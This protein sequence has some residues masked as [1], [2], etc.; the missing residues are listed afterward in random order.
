MSKQWLLSLVLFLVP[1]LAFAQTGTLSGV[2]TDAE[3]GDV[4]PGAQLDLRIVHG[5]DT[6][7]RD[8]NALVVRIFEEEAFPGL[9]A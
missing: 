6:P 3:T 8:V 4:M 1:G 2:V 7:G 9:K 5:R